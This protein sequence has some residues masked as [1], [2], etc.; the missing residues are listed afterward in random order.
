M[1]DSQEP[2]RQL[3]LEESLA[4]LSVVSLIQLVGFIA[5]VLLIR[6]G[7][8]WFKASSNAPWQRDC[9]RITFVMGGIS[10]GALFLT[11]ILGFLFSLNATVPEWVIWG[12]FGINTAVF[13][14][15][16]ARTGGP[17]NSFFGQLVPLQLSG[18]LVLEQQ[19]TMMTKTPLVTWKFAAFS[20]LV[21][22]VVV[23]FRRNFAQLLGWKNLVMGPGVHRFVLF[24]TTTLF[25]LSVAVTVLA[26]WLPPRK[27]VIQFI[28]RHRPRETTNSS[29]VRLD[30]FRKSKISFSRERG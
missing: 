8:R 9:L 5:L 17:S 22:L 30:A 18:I 10:L 20:V 4:R 7:P 14:L 24:A 28:E 6:F 19:R 29:L 1:W 21:W 25:I 15:G 26:Y 12:V 11:L 2:I 23:L 27:E 13:S 3:S 16:M